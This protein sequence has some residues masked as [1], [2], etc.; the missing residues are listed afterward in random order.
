METYKQIRRLQNEGVTSQR[1]A[2]KL[3]GISRNTVKK[4][5]EGDRVPWDR[6]PYIR[7][8]PVMTPEVVTFVQRCLDEDDKSNIRKQ[9][10]T[11]RRIFHRL[12]DELG[13]TGSEA[14]VRKLVHQL[15]TER[16]GGD[17]SVPL[18]FAP[19]EAVQIDW[20]EAN[21]VLNGEKVKVYLF[22]ARLCYSCAP[23]V[24]A[25][26]RQNLESFLDAITRTI[27]YFGGV[28][29]KFV[30]D[31][32]KVAVKS[33]FGAHAA[34]QDDYAHLAAHYS[35]EPVF[36]NPCSGNE[37][38]LV[39]NLVGYIRRNVC[40][41]I[42]K[43]EDLDELNVMLLTKCVQYG[44][45]Q[46]DGKEDKVSVMLEEERQV[47]YRIPGYPLDISRKVFARVNR[48]CMVK[49]DTNSYS[50]PCQYCGRE[51]TLH[52]YPNHI[53]VWSEGHMIA[54]HGRLFGRK[55]EKLEL[56]HYLPI[57][58]QKRRALRNARPMQKYFPAEFIDWLESQN[59]TSRELYSTL[60]LCLDNDYAAVMSGSISCRPQ[61]EE[62]EDIVVVQGVDLTEYDV[63]CTAEVVV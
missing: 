9:K 16:L 61:K 17:A 18:S 57:L 29:R 3:L 48:Y 19:G 47:L 59:F 63:L 56:E 13:F 1:Q 36:C 10:H 32:A 24:L 44:D 51:V 22:C 35:F 39:E 27:Q 58:V 46:I 38:G 40:V 11:A 43:V 49:Y 54:R 33:G 60:T 37:K 14:S 20:G 12:A 23:F 4:Y 31:N 53:E 26:R 34:A 2:A 41:P 15:H 50:V 42:P 7:E 25:Y 5:W 52:V 55:Q 30:F 45:H 8:S 62:I 6:K 28:P 21:I